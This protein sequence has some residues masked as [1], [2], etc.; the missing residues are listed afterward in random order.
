VIQRKTNL[1]LKPRE[2]TDLQITKGMHRF[3]RCHR[4][5][6]SSWPQA[7]TSLKSKQVSI[8]EKKRCK[9]DSNKGKSLSETLNE[10]KKLQTEWGKKKPGRSIQDKK[11]RQTS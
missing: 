7:Q 2:L 1:H 5:P 9:I 4:T 3:K 8:K 10:N 11:R 6:S